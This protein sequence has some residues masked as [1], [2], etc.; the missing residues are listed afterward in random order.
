METRA[1]ATNREETV[2]GIKATLEETSSEIRTSSGIRTS[3]RIRTSSATTKAIKEETN[4]AVT[5]GTKSTGA[6]SL[7]GILSASRGQASK[8]TIGTTIR[9]IGTTS[10]AA[11]EEEGEEEEGIMEASME[12]EVGAGTVSGPE[13][14]SEE[15]TEEEAE[16]V[17]TATDCL[18]SEPEGACLEVDQ[19]SEQFLMS[20]GRLNRG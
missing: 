6:G 4:E 13:V 5:E 1:T 8:G 15:E 3:S 14:D 9:A 20:K 18:G 11:E 10:K 17:N 2:A 12:A 19:G 16:E 7:V